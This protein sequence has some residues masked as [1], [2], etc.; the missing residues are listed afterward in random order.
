MKN[1]VSKW[2]NKYLPWKKVL[3][4]CPTHVIRADASAAT[5]TYE[6]QNDQTKLNETCIVYLATKTY[7]RIRNDWIIDLHLK[8]G[9]LNL[10][11]K[12]AQ[13]TKVVKCINKSLHLAFVLANSSAYLFSRFANCYCHAKLLT[14]RQIYQ[15]RF[16]RWDAPAF[17]VYKFKRR[18]CYRKNNIRALT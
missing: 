6:S 9:T 7:Q 4:L 10:N 13:I 16:S 5:A 8:Y 12:S 11:R 14:A 18:I 3:Q 2:C 15:V 1:K 17:I